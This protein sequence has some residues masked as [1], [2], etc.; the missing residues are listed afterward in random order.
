MNV[1]PMT[2]DEKVSEA[3]GDE[4]L[5]ELVVKEDLDKVIDWLVLHKMQ[6]ESK[7]SA[8]KADLDSGPKLPKK[9]YGEYLDWRRRTTFFLNL[10][11]RRLAQAKI[12]QKKRNQERNERTYSG[13]NNV[14]WA[15]LMQLGNGILAYLEEDWD[16]EDLERLLDTIFLPNH[17]ELTPLR[18]L[19][20]NW[21][22]TS[23]TSGS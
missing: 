4:E 23:E 11:A 21:R 19:I 1:T 13:E 5:W 15:V 12:E 16:E 17:G 22:K 18:T 9:E 3:L 10:L 2:F 14:K 20:K 6:V 7:L 8:R